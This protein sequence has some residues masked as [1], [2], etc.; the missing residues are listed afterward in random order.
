MYGIQILL[1]SLD[2]MY[3]SN[4]HVASWAVASAFLILQL[5]E[6][7]AVQNDDVVFYEA[8]DLDALPQNPKTPRVEMCRV[9]I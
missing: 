4:R 9:G 1:E 7:L 5:L 8:A 6:C 3:I 2:G